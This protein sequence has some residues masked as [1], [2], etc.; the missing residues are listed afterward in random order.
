[1]RSIDVEFTNVGPVEMKN[2]HVAVSH[3]DCISLVS[4]NEN[5]EDFKLLYDEKY[6]V[7]PSDLG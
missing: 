4:P 2:L 7:P 6:R 1:M 5:A 3:P